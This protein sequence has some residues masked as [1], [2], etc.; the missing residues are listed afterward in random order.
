MK[1]IG[2]YKHDNDVQGTFVSE[3]SMNITARLKN[4]WGLNKCKLVHVKTWQGYN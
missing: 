1:C 3:V 4:K 2:G